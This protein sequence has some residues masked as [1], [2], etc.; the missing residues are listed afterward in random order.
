MN[1]VYEKIH[2]GTNQQTGADKIGLSYNIGTYDI[3]FKPNKLTY[4]TTPSS[5]SPYTVLNI[6]DSKLQN[7]GAIAGDN[8]LMSDKVFK[9]RMDIKN[10]NYSHDTD[11]TYLCSWLSGNQD[12]ETKWVDRY[13]NPNIKDF[14]AALSATSYYKVVTAAGAET[15]ETFDVS[16]SLTFEPNNDYMVYHIG[17]S[18]Y[19]NLFD[20]YDTK[21]NSA[22]SGAIEYL[23]HKGVPKTVNQVL[24]E[25]EISLDGE[26]FGR[27]KTDIIGDFS[28]NFWLQTQDKG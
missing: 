28:I 8:P 3:E 17:T 19:K 11:P 25:D 14:N 24:N 21:Y 5:L 27:L 13:Y 22:S 6:K 7:L 12:G 20:A 16:S 26:T 1:R 18:D 10:N 4:F 23:S 9:R 15:T 2:A